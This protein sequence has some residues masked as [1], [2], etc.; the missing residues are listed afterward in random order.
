MRHISFLLAASALTV[1]AAVMIAAPAAAQQITSS[2]EG[3]VAD[4]SGAIVPGATVVVRDERTG[5]QRTVTTGGQG[6]F[7]VG[8]LT[9]GGPYSVTATA[10][11]YQG[12]TIP[13]IQ[14]QP[15]AALRNS[16]SN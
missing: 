2:V 5:T 13:D 14:L 15:R 4:A 3:T 8:N 11:G 12:Q 6:R 1:P 9:T 10:D 7:Q 16:A